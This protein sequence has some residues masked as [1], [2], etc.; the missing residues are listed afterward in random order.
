MKNLIQQICTGLADGHD[1]VLATIVSRSG[2]TPRQAGARMV[3]FRD[4]GSSGTIGGGPVEATALREA[5][6][7]FASGRSRRIS[8]N[9]DSA[10][11]AASDM[12]C[13]GRLELFLDY[14]G[15]G[16]SNGRV[17][18][19]LLTA[20]QSGRRV[21]LVSRMTDEGDPDWRFVVDHHGQ[22]SRDEIPASLLRAIEEARR[23]SS[24][25]V[26]I[27]DQGHS[28]LFSPFAAAG[29]VYLLGAGHV[30][31]CTAEAA[32]RVGFR[33]VVMDDR[34]A[35][36]NRD[37][38]PQADE[39]RVLPSFADC[40]HGLAIDADACLVI[41]TRGHLHDLEVLAQAL[42][43]EAGYIGMIGSR[44]KREAIYAALQGRGVSAAQLARVRCP[45]GMAIEADT[46]EEIAV[47][48]VGELIL[49]RATARRHGI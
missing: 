1:L 6:T 40:L 11:A 17:F 28:Y 37:R 30:A 36:A 15:A 43:T 35:F 25:S 21:A 26:L 24:A 32:V 46:P 39:I 31:A 49:H 34:A 27:E 12:I 20:V 38:F 22:T 18:R 4:G 8:F 41:L 16:E 2:S 10:D 23:A 47:S 14:I 48:I 29:T 45:I 9:L 3:M 19:E 33:V 5:A 44:R 13:G 42:R 7:C